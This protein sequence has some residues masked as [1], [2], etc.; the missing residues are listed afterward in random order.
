MSR[1]Y[2]QHTIDQLEELAKDPAT[3]PETLLAVKAELP[4]RKKTRQRADQ[5]L[6]HIEKRLASV[7]PKSPESKTPKSKATK[8]S[9][10]G[11]D[12]DSGAGAEL[13]QLRREVKIL[14]DGVSVMAECLERWGLSISAPPA[15]IDLAA[16]FWRR[17]LGTEPDGRGRTI[18]TLE[19]DLAREAEFRKSISSES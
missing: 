15:L 2:L 14:R 4:H 9:S 19:V 6:S 10:T 16:E 3:E 12:P 8:R 17:N 13:Q 18:K 5:I 7:P 11:S 1:E